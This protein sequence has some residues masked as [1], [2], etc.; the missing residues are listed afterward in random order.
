M[1]ALQ[2]LLIETLLLANQSGV[3]Q[4]ASGIH[5]SPPVR[6]YLV[7]CSIRV[8]NDLKQNAD[9]AALLKD[10]F[11][12][13]MAKNRV[14]KNEY[15]VY[16]PN[17]SDFEQRKRTCKP[18]E[19]C[20]FIKLMEKL[21]PP[22]DSRFVLVELTFESLDE[23]PIDRPIKKTPNCRHAPSAEQCRE[24][25]KHILADEWVRLDYAHRKAEIATP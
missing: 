4:E 8:G 10:I 9:E 16:T 23:T 11:T 21:T 12:D 15:H 19:I 25:Y 22:P 17:D 18:K 6:R 20:A 1:R 2:I 7:V 24:D 13:L 5:G 14:S 3:S